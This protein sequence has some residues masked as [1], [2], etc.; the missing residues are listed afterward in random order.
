MI[1]ISE[2]YVLAGEGAVE[3]L[4]VNPIELGGLFKCCTLSEADRVS[5]AKSGIQALAFRPTPSMKPMVQSSMT[6]RPSSCMNI[7]R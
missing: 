7:G 3:F 4:S 5:E 6:T 2:A 1:R